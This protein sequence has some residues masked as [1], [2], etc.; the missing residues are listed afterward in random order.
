[1]KRQK[2]AF[3]FLISLLTG[4]NAISQH[5]PHAPIAGQVL[6][7][8]IFNPAIAGSKDFLALDLSA[9]VQGSDISQLLSASTRLTEEGPRYSGAPVA[10]TFTRFGIGASLFNDVL[11]NSRN[12][13]LSAAGAYHLP[14]NER[15]LS[16]LSVGAALKGIVNLTD[17]IIE[18]G[19]PQKTSFIP[20]LD[21]GM[22]YY[23]RN[24]YVGI[25]ATN[26][27]GSMSDSTDLAVYQIPVSRQ[28]FFL[29]GYKIVLSR[30]LNIVLEPSLIINL[31]DSLDF[32]A[33]E[34]Y[35]PMLRIYMEAFCI[36]AYLH[37]YENLTF[38][39]QY[40]F[41][42]LYLGTLVDFPRDVPFYKKDLTIEIVAGVNFGRNYGYSPNRFN[43]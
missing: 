5:T 26:I 14:M 8:F 18:L 27:L 32:Q 35:N 17:S 23:S 15:K 39:F 21:V 16:F 1:M 24:L 25:S 12:L 22:Y 11:G 9:V 33:K 2:V 29:A 13:G 4:N 3:F 19:V 7:P 38:F 43:W 36:G 42:R 28:Y 30:S 34:T 20:N 37:N 41:P 6:T 40:K 31:N 10:K